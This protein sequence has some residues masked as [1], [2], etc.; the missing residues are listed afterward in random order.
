MKKWEKHFSS[1]NSKS[2]RIFESSTFFQ[3]T[4]QLWFADLVHILS[5]SADPIKMGLGLSSLISMV[6]ITKSGSLRYDFIL[7]K[8]SK[9]KPQKVGKV[10]MADLKITVHY[11]RLGLLNKLSYWPQICHIWKR[12]NNWDECEIFAFFR[13]QKGFNFKFSYVALLNAY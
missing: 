7:F 13:L 8:S 4:K 5:I 9:K 10:K 2:L 1:R 6:V 11:G 3:I 12:L